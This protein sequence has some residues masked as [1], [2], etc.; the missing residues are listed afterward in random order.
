MIS[1]SLFFCDSKTL[2]KNRPPA[3]MNA[4]ATGFSLTRF[5]IYY[6]IALSTL[7]LYD[8]LNRPATIIAAQPEQVHART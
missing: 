2:R 3:G 6:A 1:F 5:Y 7:L 4:P 8:A